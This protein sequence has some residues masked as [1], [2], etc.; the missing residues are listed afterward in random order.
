MKPQFVTFFGI[1]Q[2]KTIWFQRH[3]Y[4]AENG[5]VQGF[6]CAVK[7]GKKEKDEAAERGAA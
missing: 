7:Q 5:R 6:A 4:K 1:A 2:R 3:Q